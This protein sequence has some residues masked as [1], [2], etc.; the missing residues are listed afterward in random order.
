MVR[1]DQARAN[2]FGASRTDPDH[3]LVRLA[4]SSLTRTAG[5]PPALLP[6][7]GGSLPGDVFA[8]VLG[9]PMVW[10]P[11]SY[12]GC[13]QHAPDEHLLLPLVEEGLAIMAGLF[14]D[15]GARTS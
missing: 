6:N 14:W 8:E 13:S 2:L 15:L 7:T 11:H 3:P 4:V 9:L 10:V 12:G 1:I 5:R